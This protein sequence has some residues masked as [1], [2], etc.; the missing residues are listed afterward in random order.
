MVDAFELG[1]DGLGVMLNE[2]AKVSRLLRIAIAV[3][4]WKKLLTFYRD[5]I[6]EHFTTYSIDGN[7]L[8]NEEKPS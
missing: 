4:K 7:A 5:E 2:G 6:S 8:I 3:I 1:V